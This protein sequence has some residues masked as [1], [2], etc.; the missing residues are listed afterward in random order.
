MNF[1]T[2]FY[3]DL[4][5]QLHLHHKTVWDAR[6]EIY[7]TSLLVYITSSVDLITSK[8]DLFFMA[9]CPSFSFSFSSS[10]YSLLPSVRVVSW[11]VHC[12]TCTG[13]HLVC[14]CACMHAYVCTLPLCVWACVVVIVIFWECFSRTEV[15]CGRHRWCPLDVKCLWRPG[16]PLVHPEP[17]VMAMAPF[18]CVCVC[19]CNG[20]RK[21]VRCC[22]F[23]MLQLDHAESISHPA[24]KQNY[25]LTENE[26][27]FEQV[28]LTT[29]L[30]Y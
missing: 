18:E 25:F 13:P 6:I 16:G 10:F 1:W 12:G 20:G 3:S 27:W 22:L 28:E 19:V 23:L 24:H 4:V 26:N 15:C 5:G 30:Y 29:V 14:M 11:C 7:W 17:H 9:I 2:I 8:P 21:G